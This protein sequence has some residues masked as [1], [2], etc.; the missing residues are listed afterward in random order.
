MV[1]YIAA[2]PL[3][4]LYPT[5][6]QTTYVNSELTSGTVELKNEA[7]QTTTSRVPC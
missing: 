1:W 5:R 2:G 6:V 7:T 3:F 4:M